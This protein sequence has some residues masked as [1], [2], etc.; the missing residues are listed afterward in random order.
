MIIASYVTEQFFMSFPEDQ[1]DMNQIKRA[2]HFLNSLPAQK[3]LPTTEG[4]Q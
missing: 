3:D 1:F 4:I 2:V